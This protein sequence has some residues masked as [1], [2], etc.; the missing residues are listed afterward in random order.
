M[1]GLKPS[2]ERPHR[3]DTAAL[4]LAGRVGSAFA[5]GGDLGPPW[6]TPSRS[7]SPQDP[8]ASIGARA[9]R[10]VHRP[11]GLGAIV[12]SSTPRALVPRQV[13]QWNPHRPLA[14]EEM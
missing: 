14:A 7:R 6:D 11:S 8:Q 2:H 4:A 10:A 12:P 5:E 1:G 3:E 13:Q 9:F